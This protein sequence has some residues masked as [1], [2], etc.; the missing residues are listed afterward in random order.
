MSIHPDFLFSP[1]P[2]K[3][4]GH[5]HLR[6]H[7]MHHG[8]KFSSDSQFKRCFQWKKILLKGKTFLETNSSTNSRN[9][10]IFFE[11]TRWHSLS[12]IINETVRERIE[13]IFV[14]K[15]QTWVP[16]EKCFH[17][18]KSVIFKRNTEMIWWD[19]VGGSNY[20]D[21][22]TLLK[23]FEVWEWMMLSLSRAIT[24]SLKA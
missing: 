15:A 9:Q 14:C 24:T 5:V 1:N 16:S 23:V 20:C 12:I 18:L 19:V 10:F 21:W 11:N 7:E 6:L 4:F 17:P 3:K 2:N 8:R 22:N 13:C